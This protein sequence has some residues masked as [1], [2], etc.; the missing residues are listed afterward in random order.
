MV[1]EKCQE[2]L[3]ALHEY[4]CASEFSNQMQVA[5]ELYSIATG[6]VNDDDPFYE[7]RMASFQEFFLFDYRLS[8][9]FSGATVFEAF[10]MNAQTRLSPAD[11]LCF[12]QLRNFRHSLFLV[13]KVRS[14]KVLVK[15]LLAR[16]D[17]MVFP[18]PEFSFAGFEVRQIFEG[19]L[20]NFEG[21]NF[22]TGAFIFHPKDVVGLIHK[23]VKDFLWS[24][25]HCKA[26]EDVD[27]RAEI[28]R[29]HDL[30]SNVA[31]QKRQAERAEKKRAIDVLNVSKQ[32]VNVSRVVS[33]PNLV[34]SIG[35]AEV[36]SPFIPETLFYEPLGLMQRLAYCEIRSFRYKHIDPVKVYAF[37]GEDLKSIPPKNSIPLGSAALPLTQGAAHS[38]TPS[39]EPSDVVPSILR[40]EGA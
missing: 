19:R 37:E 30:L 6:K 27:W 3:N 34:M 18:L 2:L 16:V 4:S 10:L 20:L 21:V 32:L 25:I 12:E 5:R 23:H 9:V 17:D 14:D 40:Q 24:N 15:D 8:E 26:C 36:L 22:F 7:S 35:R 38:T 28:S 13:E 11:L 1:A 39:Q 33:S 31:Q 29:R